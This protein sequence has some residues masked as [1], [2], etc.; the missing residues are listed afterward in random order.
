MKIRKQVYD[1]TLEDFTNSLVWEFALDEETEEG[2]DEAT[3]R[4]YKFTGHLNPHDGMFVVQ[5]E[6]TL[7]DGSKLLG[8]LSPA[9]ENELGHIQP[10]IITDKGQ[11]G[12]WSGIMQPSEDAIASKYSLLGKSSAQV[13]PLAFK[14]KVEISDGYKE[15]IING[16]SFY[17]QDRKVESIK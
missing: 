11:V 5:A 15:G 16:F 4:P 9:L 13:F 3:V 14:S 7:A 8:Y 12:F 17:S 6:F 10:I 1:L 2:Q